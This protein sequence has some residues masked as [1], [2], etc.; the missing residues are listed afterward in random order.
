MNRTRVAHDD[1]Q[2]T[3]QTAPQTA[4][5]ILRTGVNID[6]HTHLINTCISS[7]THLILIRSFIFSHSFF[8]IPIQWL[9]WIFCMPWQVA[10]WPSVLCRCWLGA[11]KSIRPVKNWVMRCWCGY[12]SAA[13]WFCIWSSWCHCHPDISCF[14]KI[15]IGLTFWCRLTRLSWKEAIKRVTVCNKLLS[16]LSLL[17]NRS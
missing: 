11:M 1:L 13:R 7:H 16:L 15:Q 12:P 8:W 6:S 2:L 5:V 4:S 10:V 17:S 14:I 9:L 3:P